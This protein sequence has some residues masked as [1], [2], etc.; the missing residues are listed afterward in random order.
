MANNDISSSTASTACNAKNFQGEWSLW[1][2]KWRGKLRMGSFS[3][4]ITGMYQTG[5]FRA[6]TILG[7]RQKLF[8]LNK[9]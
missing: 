8:V 4:C 2:G 6:S 1:L 3:V 7:G 5:R 9:A